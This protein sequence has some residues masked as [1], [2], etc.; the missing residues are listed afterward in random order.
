MYGCADVAF[1]RVTWWTA[2]S[3]HD[4]EIQKSEVLIIV[5][6]TSLQPA[7]EEEL[8]DNSTKSIVRGPTQSSLYDRVRSAK[9]L[10]LTDN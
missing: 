4:L 10:I 5:V 9:V 8:F 3:C 6:V 1:S 7:A 2:L